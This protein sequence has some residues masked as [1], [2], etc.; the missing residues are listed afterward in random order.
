MFLLV[1][2]VLVLLAVIFGGLFVGIVRGVAAPC[3]G[4]AAFPSRLKRSLV[5][6]DV[7]TSLLAS[8][9]PEPWCAAAPADDPSPGL[10]VPDV[11]RVPAAP[12]V[13]PLVGVQPVAYAQPVARPLPAV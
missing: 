9:R 8:G 7:A 6:V 10:E 1:L 2:P 3:G 13:A 4:F 11:P 5:T 12:P